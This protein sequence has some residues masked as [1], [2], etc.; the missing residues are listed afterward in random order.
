MVREVR[1]GSGDTR[2]RILDAALAQF[3]DV[4]YESTSM[5][6]IALAAGVAKGTLYYHFDSKTGIVDAIVAR[7]AD[8]I[9]ETVAGILADSTQGVLERLR[10]VN[11]ELSRLSGRT[12]AQLHRMSFIDIH[13]RTTRALFTVLPPAFARLFEEGARQGLWRATH[14]LELSEILVAAGAYVFDPEQ[15]NERTR[16]RLD[17]FVEACAGA[18]GIEP[19]ILRPAFAAFGEP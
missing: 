10:L 12:F 11:V 14:P 9:E 18:L 19:G 15:A 5:D 8:S 6:A 16:R 13:K 7:Y 1:S 17:A 3:V 4:G 2:S